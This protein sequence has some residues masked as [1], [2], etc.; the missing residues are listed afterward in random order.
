MK[1]HLDR[2][3]FKEFIENLSAKTKIDSDIIEKDYYVSMI[4]K[5]L[6]LKQD[7]IQAYFKGGTALY[8]ILDTTNRFSEDIDLT[9]KVFDS[10]SNTRNR[11]RL[12]ESALGYK[13]DGLELDK[14]ESIINKG[15][16]IGIYKYDSLFNYNDNSLH[17]KGII[18]V[19]STSFTVSEPYKEYNI[20]PLIYKL[21]NDNEKLIL[22]ENFNIT[23]F[24]I[25]IITL[26]RIF[27]DKLF[28]TEFYY[29]RNMYFD[30]SKHLYDIAILYQKEEIK[31]LLKNQGL[32]NE[33]ISYKRKEELS[34]R[35]GIV[36]SLK[37]IDFT[38]FKLDFNDQL[39]LEFRNMQDKYVLNDNYKINIEFVIKCLKQIQRELKFD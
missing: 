8:K 25:N 17:K 2:R 19:E 28:A 3:L 10:Q 6:S 38:Y 5:E 34:R 24:N 12:K 14:N 37:I 16:V 36:S 21:S 39:L 23:N 9:V 13:I 22:K 31:N 27:I 30:T 15:S 20:E 32:L 35:F 7:Y 11:N 29:I 26:E 1:L 4:L 18:Q 33:L